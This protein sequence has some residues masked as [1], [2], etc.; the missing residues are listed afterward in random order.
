MLNRFEGALFLDPVSARGTLAGSAGPEVPGLGPIVGLDA[1]FDFNQAYFKV[2]GGVTVA[3]KRLA[4]ALVEYYT[5][6]Q[7]HARGELN[8]FIDA[9]K[10]YGFGGVVDGW[11]SSTAFNVEGQVAFRAK[12]L[13]LEGKGVVSSNGVAG[14][15]T[16]AGPLWSKVELGAGYR[17]G[18][19]YIDWI[20]GSCDLGPYSAAV[21]RAAIRQA[22]TNTVTLPG[23]LGAASIAVQGT[24]AAPRVTLT[25]PKGETVTAPAGGESLQDDRFLV[26]Q[27]DADDTTYIAIAKPSAGAWTVTAEP[28]S[29]P[30]A[31]ILSAEAL[32]E[33][34]VTAK[35]T[36][37]GAR[38]TLRYTV[39][40]I[41]GQTVRFAEEGTDLGAELGRAKGAKGTLTFRPATGG[42]V[43]RTIVAYVEQDGLVRTKLVVGRYRAPGGELAAPRVRA[44]RKGSA[45]AVSWSAVP[46]AA[47]YR[48]STTLNGRTVL[49]TV[50]GRKTTVAGLL[51]TSGAKVTV[52]ALGGADGLGKIGKASI[53][54]PKLRKRGR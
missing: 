4:D 6:G 28:G 27:Q 18:A 17:W 10:E 49:A 21:R 8:Y 23:G 12:S 2:T 38:R 25:G 5:S 46:G 29:A 30:I 52:Q 36:G 51:P 54:A 40:P 33:P 7:F 53:K 39:K 26:I 34:K 16:V 43:A 24:G 3:G 31:K 41:P 47:G 19:Q 15:A 1:S 13:K 50:K 11:A 32:P 14:C 20:G 37:A 9:N 45:V 35:V 42:A 22:G 48:V 44:K